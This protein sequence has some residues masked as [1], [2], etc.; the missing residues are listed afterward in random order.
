M[1][2]GKMTKMSSVFRRADNAANFVSE[3][4]TK[5]SDSK[6][7]RGA[8][9]VEKAG[10]SPTRFAVGRWQCLWHE[11]RGTFDTYEK[12]QHY[13]DELNAISEREYGKD[14]ADQKRQAVRR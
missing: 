13:A 9:K 4:R 14:A 11:K 7:R 8:W 10:R 3:A 12:A 2:K 6:L 1:K 5:R